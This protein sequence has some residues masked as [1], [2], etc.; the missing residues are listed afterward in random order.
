MSTAVVL[1]IGTELTRG[2]IV[3][4]NAA[5]LAASLSALGFEVTA[6]ESVDD[7]PARIVA[8]LRRLAASHR[9][10]IATGGLGPTTDDLTAE[11]A[12]EAAGVKLAT[13]ELSLEA[14]KRRFEQLG[15]PMSPSN[16]KQAVVPE[17]ADVLPNAV[18]TAP[19]FAVALGTATAFFMPGVP[20]EV[21][22]MWRDQVEP[23]LR[24]LAQ[25]K[26]YQIRIK[27][28]GLPESQVGEQLAGLEGNP[29]YPGLVLGYRATS[30]EIE[31]KILVRG[32]N[33]DAARAV[34]QQVADE[35]KQRLGGA[36]YGEGDDTFPEA[37]ARAV[38]SRGWRLA[39]AE[40]CTGGLVGHLI[41][42]V[43]A[44][45]FFVADAV[46]YA[47]SAKT[48]LLGVDEDVLRAHGAVS[49]E[50]AAA[51]AE[52]IKRA[53]GVE[54]SLAITGIAGPTGGT[55]EKPVGLVYWAV[56]HPGGTVVEHRVLSGDRSQIQRTAAFIGISL[57]R[58][59]CLADERR[60]PMPAR[61]SLAAC[62]LGSL[63]AHLQR[64]VTAEV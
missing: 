61:A 15:R 59:V 20:F 49:A 44:S 3:N 60:T 31:V 5:L 37:L 9:V 29:L 27:T 8:V 52:G 56:S 43:P 33:E 11:A 39:I 63:A 51:M 57:L 13:H 50:V 45:E 46:T 42:S 35:V 4:T 14:I 10:I 64:G 47:N 41:T 21:E 7:D 12:A 48:R 24:P 28:F 16:A 26:S 55:P 40:S 19:G 32:A 18:G 36:I 38:R 2:E 30:P 62:L 53:C 25:R 22:R 23:R 54:L 34:A 58:Q 17:G 1:S 6:H